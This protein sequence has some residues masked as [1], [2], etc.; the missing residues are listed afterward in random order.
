MGKNYFEM[1]RD[2]ILVD[3]SGGGDA[4]APVLIEKSVTANGTYT[5]SSDNADGYS[6]VT[7]DVPSDTPTLIT[8]SI[9]ANGTYSASDDSADGYSSVSVDVH[10]TL[11]EKTVSNMGTYNASD[12]NAD[13]YSK[14]VVEKSQV[15]PSVYNV[16]VGLSKNTC[17]WTYLPKYFYIDSLSPS[18]NG[19]VVQNGKP[20]AQTSTTV[21]TNGTIDTTTN[22]SVVVNVANS[23]VAADEGKVVS[24][25]ALVAQ[26]SDSVTEN[27][28]V[29]TT[30]IN[31]LLVNVSASGNIAY[32]LSGDNANDAYI[33]DCGDYIYIFGTSIWNGSGTSV[34]SFN[35]TIPSGFDVSKIDSLSGGFLG[36]GNYYTKLYPS[37]SIT[38]SGNNLTLNFNTTSLPKNNDIWTVVRITKS[39]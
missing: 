37:G 6:S 7:V 2:G 23:Y 24:N 25:G 38:I 14:V 27:G 5:A 11:V 18:Y 13:G 4:P 35:Y 16:N 32:N 20:V 21:T 28:T 34:S 22:N 8:K 26:G 9:S 30:L 10:P 36:G 29:D 15:T 17:P 33:I 1:I 39:T 31:S 12:D 3:G 19:R